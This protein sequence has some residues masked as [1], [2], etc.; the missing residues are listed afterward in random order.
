MNGFLIVYQ[1]QDYTI[2][3]IKKKLFGRSDYHFSDQDCILDENIFNENIIFFKHPAL[4][5]IELVENNKG[6]YFIKYDI[7]NQAKLFEVKDIYFPKNLKEEKLCL[8]EIIIKFVELFKGKALKYLKGIVDIYLIIYYKRS[9]NLDCYFNNENYASKIMRAHT[10]GGIMFSDSLKLLENFDVTSIEVLENGEWFNKEICDIQDNYKRAEEVQKNENQVN[11]EICDNQNNYKYTEVHLKDKIDNGFYLTDNEYKTNPAIGREEELNELQKL[12][13]IPNKGVVLIGEAGVGKT[14]L[15][16]GLAY[17][18]RKG[19]VSKF[20]RNKGILSVNIS[21]LIAD[22]HFRGSLEEKIK[23][24]CVALQ[25]KKDVILF[26]DEIHSVIGNGTTIDSN[27]DIANI[28]KPYISENNIKVIGCTTKEEYM[29]FFS[30]DKAFS[31][32][33]NLLEIKEPNQDVLKQ[34]L[35]DYIYKNEF[36]IKINMSFAEMDKLLTYIIKLSKRIIKNQ[37]QVLQNP[38]SS[39]NIL[40]NCFAY[41]AYKDIQEANLQD[42]LNGIYDNKN[43]DFTLAQRMGINSDFENPANLKKA[44]VYDL[45]AFQ[46]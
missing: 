34:I 23:N 44:K 25:N 35:Q 31:R 17:L 29:K 8:Q 32:R 27:N 6:I 33:F 14:A 28:L 22:T 13:L 37:F 24:L 4:K 26:L 1:G 5:N 21:S 2:N 20:L 41:L 10:H 40:A 39:I 12:I 11:K 43:Y 18:I 7:I 19:E 36:N 45:K 38:D 42:F 46:K 9:K 15:V 3:D 30:T 16:K